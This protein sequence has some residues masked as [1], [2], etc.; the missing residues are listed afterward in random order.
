MSLNPF[1]KIASSK[2]TSCPIPIEI[3]TRLVSFAF[4]KCVGTHQPPYSDPTRVK[5]F[6]IDALQK[7]CVT[8]LMSKRFWV[9]TR[10]KISQY[11]SLC[12]LEPLLFLFLRTVTAYNIETV[13]ACKILP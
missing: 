12:T 10:K 3:A 13:L 4:N 11:L 1:L 7:P 9:L 6:A 8:I 2:V 5:V